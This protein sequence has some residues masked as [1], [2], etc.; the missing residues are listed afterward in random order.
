MNQKQKQKKLKLHLVHSSTD[1]FELIKV[2]PQVAQGN[3][4]Q[5]VQGA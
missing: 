3:T 2:R 1:E 5:K 4:V